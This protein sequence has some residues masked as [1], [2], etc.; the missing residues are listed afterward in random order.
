M[1][2]ESVFTL[3][4]ISLASCFN[5]YTPT[6][7]QKGYFKINFPNKEYKEYYSSEC[8]FSFRYPKYA[9]LEKDMHY[10]NEQQTNPCWINL[11]IPD[12][13]ATLHISY[14]EIKSPDQIETFLHDSHDLSWKHTIKASYIKEESVENQFKKIY[15]RI[16]NIGGNAASSYQFYLTDS[17]SHFLRASLYFENKP[18]I[19]SMGLVIDF[20]K[21]DVDHFIETFEWK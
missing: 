19:D 7:K 8:P 18:N 3:I 13:K 9:L 14:K 15:G 20:V 6:P 21:K 17:I 12:F 16:Y 1:L 2:K 5:S 10:F 4:M 11:K